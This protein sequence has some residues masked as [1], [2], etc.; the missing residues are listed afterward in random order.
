MENIDKAREQLIQELEALRRQ[1]AEFEK[2]EAE[3][4]RAEEEYQK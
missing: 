1:V 3:R 2:L 4:K